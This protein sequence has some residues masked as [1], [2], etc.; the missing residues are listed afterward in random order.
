M[1]PEFSGSMTPVDLPLER[2]QTD[3]IAI[4]GIAVLATSFN[5]RDTTLRSLEALRAAAGELTYHVWLV[6]DA[7]TDDTSAM[8]RQNHPEVTLIAGTGSL[9]WNGGML[10]AWQAAIAQHA[11]YYLLLNDDLELEPDS[12]VRLHSMQKELEALHGPKVISIGRVVDPDTGQTTYGGY[13][14]ASR[15]SRLNFKHVPN[16]G[17]PCDTMNGNCALIPARAT[18]DVGL[19]DQHYRHHTG[20]VDYGLRARDAGYLLI[21]TPY[22]VGRTS[23]NTAFHAKQNRLTWSNRRFVLNHPKGIPL[24]EWLYFCRRHGGWLWPINFIVRYIKIIRFREE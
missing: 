4:G 14:T 24:K 11:D 17:Q 15:L 1:H 22:P 8:V 16:G 20:D 2:L 10:K 23:F 18:Q 19:L 6:D 5:R 3:R 7:S 9:Y 13:V 21:Q 12:L